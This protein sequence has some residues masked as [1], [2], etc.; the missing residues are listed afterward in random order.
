MF[1]Y[2]ENIYLQKIFAVCYNAQN[3]KGGF[4]MEVSEALRRFR[5]T[6][7]LKQDDIAAALGVT[8]Q[9]YQPYETGRTLPSVKTIL[10]IAEAFDVST[11]Y[12]LGLSDVPRPVGVEDAEVKKAREF[13]AKARQFSEELRQFADGE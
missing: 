12:L 2:S 9:V 10:K 7:G 4:C 1:A 13:R 5:K 8:R 3:T 6:F 11:D